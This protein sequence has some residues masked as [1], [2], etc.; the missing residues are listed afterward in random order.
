TG[1]VQ[2][3]AQGGLAHRHHDRR[4]GVEDVLTAG[5]ALGAVHGD[6]AH[7]VLAEVLGDLD[8][9]VVRLARDGRVRHLQGGVDLGQI[10]GGELDVDDGTQHLGDLAGGVDL[11]AH[12]MTTLGEGEIGKGWDTSHASRYARP[13]T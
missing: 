5:D 9:E 7:R 11:R 4:A 6:A 10:A 2:D 12:G 3:A 13:L 1:D 8:G